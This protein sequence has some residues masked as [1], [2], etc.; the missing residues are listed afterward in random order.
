MAHKRYRA[1]AQRPDDGLSFQGESLP[2]QSIRVVRRDQLTSQLLERPDHNVSQPFIRRPALTRPC[3]VAYFLLNLL[4]AR[5]STI[6]VSNTRSPTFLAALP[7]VRWGEREEF[8]ATLHAG[9]SSTFRRGFPTRK[10]ILRRLFPSNGSSCGAPPNQS[11]SI[12]PTP[13][14]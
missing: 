10:S 12:C 1:A 4:P 3:R 5:Q 13:L 7:Y 11:L 14:G 6:T 9:I 2:Y 8:D